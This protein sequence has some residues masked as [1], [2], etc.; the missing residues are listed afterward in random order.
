MRALNKHNPI[1]TAIVMLIS[2]LATDVMGESFSNPSQI[3]QDSRNQWVCD[4]SQGRNNVL[5]LRC[6]DLAGMLNDHLTLSDAFQHDTTKL[7]PIWQRPDND[8]R[9]IYL[10]RIVL[11]NQSTECRVEMRSAWNP[12]Q[13]AF[14]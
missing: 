9:A 2:C 4:Y 1:L 10:A 11:C 14:R 13:I 8:D 3:P 5:Y 6:D 7:I 12:N